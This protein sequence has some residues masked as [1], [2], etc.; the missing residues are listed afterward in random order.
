[1]LFFY[2][3]EQNWLTGLWGE[4]DFYVGEVILIV[5]SICAISSFLFNMSSLTH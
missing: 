5:F 3:V 4:D 2:F 1:M